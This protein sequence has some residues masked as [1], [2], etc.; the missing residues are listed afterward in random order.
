GSPRCST[1]AATRAERSARH[2]DSSRTGVALL[3][4]VPARR[5]PF[6]T[7][8]DA[9][10][11]IRIVESDRAPDLRHRKGRVEQQLPG[12][13]HPCAAYQIHRRRAEHA[14]AQRVEVGDGHVER[15]SEPSPVERFGEVLLDVLQEREHPGPTRIDPRF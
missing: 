2:Q 4:T 5:G 15:T 12:A 6:G 3:A 9:T 10:E 8:E 1:V 13:L 7:T 11:M 14:D